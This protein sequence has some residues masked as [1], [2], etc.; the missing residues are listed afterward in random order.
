MPVVI[1]PVGGAA[2]PEA[3]APVL[4][5]TSDVDAHVWNVLENASQK[6]SIVPCMI[7][8]SFAG[9]NVVV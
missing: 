4:S 5:V 1:I 6:A 8:P 3:P 2:I 7:S 9:T